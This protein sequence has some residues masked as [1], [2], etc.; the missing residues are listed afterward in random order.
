MNYISFQQ[1]YIPQYIFDSDI[2]WTY[3]LQNQRD[4]CIVEGLYS[5]CHHYHKWNLL[6]QWGIPCLGRFP[7]VNTMDHQN[8]HHIYSIEHHWKIHICHL[9]HNLV[10]SLDFDKRLQSILN[11]SKFWSNS[12]KTRPKN[13]LKTEILGIIYEIF[14]PHAI[15]FFEVTYRG[16]IHICQVCKILCH[17]SSVLDMPQ[18]YSILQ[19]NCL[20]ID[21]SEHHLSTD[22]NHWR[23][24]LYIQK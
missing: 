12:A 20:Y 3:Y 16:D 8:Q 10:C 23:T 9:L 15:V 14:E 17:C 5:K 1:I 4:N 13:L 19:C 18:D 6:V 7:V 22:K 24:V 21:K 11:I 2:L